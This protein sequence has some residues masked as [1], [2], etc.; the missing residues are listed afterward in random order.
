M[1]DRV[2]FILSAVGF[3]FCAGRVWF[4][5][6]LLVCVCV[7]ASDLFLFFFARAVV[8]VLNGA[9][10][11]L[12]FIW[13]WKQVKTGKEKSLWEYKMCSSQKSSSCRFGGYCFSI[14]ALA[15]MN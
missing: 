6:L 9:A 11:R 3:G 15:K 10:A 2:G 1:L 5:C 14:R 12:Y 8:K 4:C 13:S 7:Y